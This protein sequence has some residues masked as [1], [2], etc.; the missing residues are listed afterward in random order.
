[1][2]RVIMTFV[3]DDTHEERHS[4]EEEMISALQRLTRG[5]AASMGMIKKVIAVDTLDCTIFHSRWDGER[6]KI[7]FPTNLTSAR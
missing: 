3:S 2:Y 7:V 6:M 5:P 4:T 1:M